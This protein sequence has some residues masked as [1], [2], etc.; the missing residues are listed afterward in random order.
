MLQDL[1]SLC[2]SMAVKDKM[3]SIAFPTIGCGKL[4][5]EPSVVAGCFKA[6]ATRDTTNATL[7]VHCALVI[8][9]K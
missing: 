7:M 1:I 8:S 9:A 5:F 2:L 3:S 4:K 6:A